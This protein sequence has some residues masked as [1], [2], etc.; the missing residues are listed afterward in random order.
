MT[1]VFEG[2]GTLQFSPDNKY[3]YAYSGDVIAPTVGGYTSILSFTN[4]SEYLVADFNFGAT[5]TTTNIGF[6]IRFNGVDII[7][8]PTREPFDK[9]YRT[10]L[11]IPPFTTVTVLADPDGADETVQTTMVAKVKGAIQQENLESITDNNKWASK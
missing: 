2:V 5:P 3:A 9:T 11:I 4:N 1:G 6:L 8:I 7:E 10:L